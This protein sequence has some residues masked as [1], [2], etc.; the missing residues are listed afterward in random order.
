METKIM[1]VTIN[2]ISYTRNEISDAIADI[3]GTIKILRRLYLES[4]SAST[5]T[6]ITE[7]QARKEYLETLLKNDVETF[8]I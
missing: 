1:T 3:S 6:R 7:L 8:D 4:G 5:A 2:Q